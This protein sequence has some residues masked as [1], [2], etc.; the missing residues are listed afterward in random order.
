MGLDD[1]AKDWI[2]ARSAIGKNGIPFT[3]YK[4][5]T[6]EHGAEER[7]ATL[8]HANGVDELGKICD[9][10][11]VLPS[12]AWLREHC[13]DET[14]QLAFNVPFRSMRVVGV[15]PL[16]AE[17]LAE[18]P[19][20]LQEQYLR[21]GPGFFGIHYASRSLAS[22]D[23]HLALSREYYAERERNPLRTDLRYGI[24]IL[25]NFL[26]RQVRSR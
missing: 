2:Y 20:D 23:D 16:N 18:Q 14:P 24:R 13:I 1:L 7:R 5:R 8:V 25:Y 15:R 19:A 26:L 22:F 11:R 9:D 4:L 12:R 3:Q 6:M 17:E 21:H 10:P